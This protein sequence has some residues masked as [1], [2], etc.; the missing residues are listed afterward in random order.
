[1]KRLPLVAAWLASLV[2]A[3]VASSS[4]GTTVDDA[5]AAGPVQLVGTLAREPLAVSPSG[6]SCASWTARI[7]GHE[8]PPGIPLGGSDSVPIER[9]LCSENDATGARLAGA[10]RSLAIDPS[11]ARA[12]AEES[13]ASLDRAP[14][15]FI[16]RCSPTVA[17][18]FYDE[19]CVLAGSTIVVRGC[20][21]GGALVPCADAGAGAW[22]MDRLPLRARRVSWE[23]FAL[24]ALLASLAVGAAGAWLQRRRASSA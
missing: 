10:T 20:V 13:Y 15:A 23:G 2:A 24:L 4:P 7:M 22:R 12:L 6:R 8:K 18:Y 21:A 3:I 17:A 9:L 5:P 16:A 14:P 1:M 19:A 11:I